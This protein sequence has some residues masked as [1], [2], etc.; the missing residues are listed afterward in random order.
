MKTNLN[1]LTNSEISLLRNKFIG[2]KVELIGDGGRFVGVVDFIGYNE[3]LTNYGFQ[4]TIDRMP[5]T[6]VKPN[7]IKLV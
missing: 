6:N 3:H 7:S 2:N 4:V 1:I 5:V